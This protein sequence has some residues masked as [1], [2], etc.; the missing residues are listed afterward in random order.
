MKKLFRIFK[1]SESG[2]AYLEFAL[3][4]PL[5]LALF[6]GAVD[7]TRYIII[8]QKLDKAVSTMSD[9]VAQSSSITSTQLNTLSMAVRQVMLPYSFSDNGYVIISS[10]S[11]NGSTPPMVNWQYAGGGS[12]VQPSQVGSSGS[13]ASWLPFPAPYN[14]MDDKENVIIT[15]V[16][17]N[18]VP[19]L[20]NSVIPSITVKKVSAFK[21]RLGALGSLG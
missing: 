19:L 14:T 12:W 13:A 16:F 8:V 9:V 20:S 10:V 11:K 6:M 7:V 5:L 21:P 1:R 18:F 3:T 2:V 17:Y 15:E 4:L